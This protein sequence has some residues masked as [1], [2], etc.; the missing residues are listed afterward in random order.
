MES[1]G[2]NLTSV[3]GSGDTIG[4]AVEHEWLT[5]VFDDVAADRRPKIEKGVETP[6][7]RVSKATNPPTALSQ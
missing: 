3:C 5:I 6:R 7:R 1:S 2:L 4:S